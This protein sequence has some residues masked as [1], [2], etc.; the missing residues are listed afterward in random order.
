MSAPQNYGGRS[1]NKRHTRKHRKP[2]HS[3]FMG[4]HSICTLAIW[5]HRFEY[6]PFQQAFIRT[7]IGTSTH[8]YLFVQCKTNNT[9]LTM[10]H[11]ARR[12]DGWTDEET[13]RMEWIRYPFV[14]FITLFRTYF[15][16][17]L[18]SAR[19]PLNGCILAAWSEHKLLFV[20]FVF[21]FFPF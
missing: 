13:Q 16:F 8:I 3:R 21:F 19:S 20:H 7:H 18:S 6:M 5:P 4:T 14:S 17:F 11:G 10:R 12:M 15:P 1:V 2:N 9:R